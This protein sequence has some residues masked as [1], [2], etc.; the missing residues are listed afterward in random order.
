MDDHQKDMWAGVVFAGMLLTLLLGGL[1]VLR[2]QG[3]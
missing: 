3:L 2:L 1:L